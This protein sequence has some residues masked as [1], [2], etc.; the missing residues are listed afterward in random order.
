MEGG[1]GGGGGDGEV[2]EGCRFLIENLVIHST[3]EL[4]A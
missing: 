4:Y 1:W 3:R 2:K